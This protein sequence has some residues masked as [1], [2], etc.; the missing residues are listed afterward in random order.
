[1]SLE[2][3]AGPECTVNRV[4]DQFHDQ[5]DASGFA[6]EPAHLDRLASL[7]IARMRFP[8]LWERTEIRRGECDWH[9]ADQS[10][11]R[12]AE[13][14][15]QPVAG[16][17]H[18]GS[19]PA[20]TSL[21]DPSFAS[22]LSDYAA[23][24]ATRYP[25]INDW[26]PVNE[27]L[28]TARFSGLYGF[29]YPHRSDD[30]SFVRAL[31]NQVRA[32]VLAMK[33]VR[34]VNPGARLVQT[35]DLGFVTSSPALAYQ[36]K[37]ENLRRWLSFDLLVGRVDR[38]HGL[39]KYLI[40]AGASEQ[41]LDALCEEPCPPDVLGINTYITSERHLDERTWIFPVQHVGGNQRD[42]Y[43]D[44]EAA[45]VNGSL[46]GGFE[47]RLRET[48]ER[49]RLPVA[50]TE[51]H[52]GCRREDQ[53]RWLHQAWRAAST[54]RAEGHDVRAVTCWAALGAFDWNS[55]VTRRNGHY[56]SGLWDLRSTP[57]RETALV[58]MARQLARGE[59]PDHPVLGGPGWWQR[60]S[61]L[62]YFPQGEVEALPVSGRP[63]LI[64]GASGTLG[65][66]FARVC[67]ARGLSYRLLG[68]ADMDIADPGSVEAALERWQPWAVVNTAG[69]VRVDEAETDARR[70]WRENV[71]GPGVLAL[72]CERHRVRLLCFSSDLVFDGAKGRPYLEADV[73]HPLNAYGRAKHEAERHVL[74]VAPR[75]LMVRS[76]AFFGPWDAHNF[77]TAGLRALRRGE[78][79]TAAHDQEVSPTY[80]PDLVH[81]ALDLLVDGEYGI[82]HLANRGSASWSG[83]AFMA[84]DAA[85]LDARLIRP[86]PGAA[87]GQRAARPRFSVL[88]SE[89]GDLMPTLQSGLERYMAEAVK[90]ALEGPACSSPA[91]AELTP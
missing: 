57:P 18:H 62:S 79:W 31:L 33:A 89:R 84:A 29:W 38:R 56:E 37:F 28:T 49:Y 59:E 22:L 72:A 35:E 34:R 66:A 1:M 23:A 60:A 43:A 88:G 71:T 69:F 77:I 80:V 13:L 68:R 12:L 19:G 41:E 50:I 6:R 85:K 5:L 51:V 86:L 27:P 15:V 26:T 83:L 63:L 64:T 45:R 55:L 81:S 25:H 58:G 76:A 70:Q 54:V 46:T 20:W 11:A 8:I 30:A 17:L 4:G 3:W 42:R 24:V 47:A 16:L 32:T 67:D 91:V 10:L 73:P 48:C 44:V 9:W 53:L 75:A 87:L 78:P 90:E 39:W 61:R 21:L 52:L 14:K 74:T 65:R 7:G 2:L 36:A 40:N 82:W